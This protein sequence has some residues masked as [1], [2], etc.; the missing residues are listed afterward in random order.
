MRLFAL[1]EGTEY[2]VLRGSVDVEVRG[3]RYDS[4]QVRPGDLFVC[5][6]GFRRD[7]HDFL[8]AAWTAGAVAALMERSDLPEN[9]LQGGTVVRVANARKDLAMV[10]CRFYGHPSQ[11]LTMVGVTGTN[12]KTTTTY[13]VESVLRRAGHQ[14]GLIGTIEYRCNGAE[15]EA[16]RTTPESSDL[17][18]LL[19]RMALLSAD[20]IVMEVSSHALALHRWQQRLN[21]WARK[22]PMPMSARQRDLRRVHQAP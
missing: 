20:S 1:I 15:M 19:E 22:R 10:A 2:Q 9:A 18:A 3:I 11:K 5:I 12:G 17:Q 16:A 14:V 6:R 8:Q 13:L 7:G 21:E 4:R